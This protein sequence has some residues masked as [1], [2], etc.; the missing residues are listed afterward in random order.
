MYWLSCVRLINIVDFIWLIICDEVVYGYYIGYKFQKGL[1]KVDNNCCQE[2]KN[3]VFDLLQDLYDNEI[4]YIESLYDGVGWI[5]DVKK[6]FY[7]NVNKVL[8]NLGYE[9]LFFVS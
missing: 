4:Y 1:E 8:M 6:F 3:F 7:Y 9:V 2:I 5:E